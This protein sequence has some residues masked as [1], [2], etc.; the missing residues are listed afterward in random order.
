MPFL[1]DASFKTT[2]LKKRAIYRSLTLTVY[3]FWQGRRRNLRETRT[4]AF[5]FADIL[6]HI[7]YTHVQLF[8][9]LFAILLVA[10]TMTI[11][12]AD[13]KL[14]ITLTLTN[15]NITLKYIY[16]QLTFKTTDFEAHKDR[17]T[18][19]D[20]WFSFVWSLQRCLALSAELCSFMNLQ[21][22][23]HGAKLIEEVRADF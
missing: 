2:G 7:R 18:V 11:C 5:L 23:C 6:V 12:C 3:H 8:S 16:L 9:K 14:Y 1:R 10:I 20:A 13:N 15:K 17:M 4:F 19:T 22:S 21:H